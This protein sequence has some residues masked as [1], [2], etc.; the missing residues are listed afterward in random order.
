MTDSGPATALSP[1]KAFTTRA[2]QHRTYATQRDDLDC[3]ETSFA[4]VLIFNGRTAKKVST[5]EE[6]EAYLNDG[7]VRRQHFESKASNLG[8]DYTSSDPSPSYL[9]HY[10]SLPIS[11]IST[12][13]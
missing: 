13:R 5:R 2:I 7:F 1:A 12:T 4:K 3:H 9:A 6:I 11:N 8:S 10:Y